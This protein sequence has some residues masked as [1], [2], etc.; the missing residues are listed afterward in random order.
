MSKH[1]I[2]VVVP[3]MDRLT[4]Q[5]WSKNLDVMVRTVF[6]MG[7]VCLYGGQSCF[8]GHEGSIVIKRRIIMKK[9]IYGLVF[10]SLMGCNTLN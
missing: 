4:N 7:T 9:I 8:K 2:G 1:D 5:E 6:P 10:L 3:L